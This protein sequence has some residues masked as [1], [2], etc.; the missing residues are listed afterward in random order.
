MIQPFIPYGTI[1]ANASNI[2]L[3]T[4]WCGMNNFGPTL[5]NNTG[6]IVCD[7]TQLS[8]II[9][10]HLFRVINN[11]YGG[12]AP[13]FNLPDYRG[14]FLRGLAM[15]AQQDPGYDSRVVQPGSTGTAKGVGS[16]QV[17]MV[18]THEHGYT[19]YPGT[20][21][22]GGDVANADSLV[23]AKSTFTTGLFTDNTGGT[24]L[25][26]EETRPKN[27][28]VFYLIYAGRPNERDSFL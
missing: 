6:W 16:T 22:P 27:V 5:E 9:F 15:N 17:C 3:T 12:T 2:N 23:N 26:G 14:Y 28:Y 21:A 24:K 20:P 8:S 1:V 18:Q 13:M 7:G 11:L 25:T 4:Y 19:D 10:P